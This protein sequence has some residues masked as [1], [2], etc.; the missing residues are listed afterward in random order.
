MQDLVSDLNN[1]NLDL[2]QLDQHLNYFQNKMHLY[3]R[4][5]M[6]RQNDTQYFEQIKN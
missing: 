3:H 2:V 1:H 5:K 6:A 4:H